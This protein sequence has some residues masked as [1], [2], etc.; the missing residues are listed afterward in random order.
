MIEKSRR[1]RAW[2]RVDSMARDRKMA[3][4]EVTTSPFSLQHETWVTCHRL[5][6]VSLERNVP[7]GRGKLLY[8]EVANR[9]CLLSW[10][11]TTHNKIFRVTSALP[12][13]FCQGQSIPRLFSSSFPS[14]S[15][16][17]PF[18]RPFFSLNPILQR[19]N[20]ILLTFYINYF[21]IMRFT[22]F[23]FSG[24]LLILIDKS[25]INIFLCNFIL[26]KIGKCTIHGYERLESMMLSWK[27]RGRETWKCAGI[28]WQV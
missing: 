15:S 13:F 23:E 17:S 12:P 4:R 8:F 3:R 22:R 27:R 18:F 20:K 16:S 7:F 21:D 1:Q 10:T 5:R 9:S 24:F 25:S 2:R 19:E 14:S 28:L 26:S 11:F 6:L